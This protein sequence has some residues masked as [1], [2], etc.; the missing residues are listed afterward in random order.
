MEQVVTL[1]RY[2]WKNKDG[3][4]DV[5]YKDDE[6]R[7]LPKQLMD[8]AP[9]IPHRPPQT[10]TNQERFDNM[11]PKARPQQPQRNICLTP[12]SRGITRFDSNRCLR[13]LTPKVK[14]RSLNDDMEQ[15]R[16]SSSP[17]SPSSSPD[18]FQRFVPSRSTSDRTP[19]VA[20]RFENNRKDSFAKTWF[21]RCSINSVLHPPDVFGSNR[22]QEQDTRDGS[23]KRFSH[24][25]SR[26]DHTP[27]AVKLPS[28][29][30]EVLEHHGHGVRQLHMPDLSERSHGQ[31]RVTS[32][33]ELH[34][35]TTSRRFQR[36]SSLEHV[37]HMVRSAF[38][39]NAQLK[40]PEAATPRS[41]AYYDDNHRSHHNGNERDED[42]LM[43]MELHIDLSAAGGDDS[44]HSQ[45]DF[46]LSRRQNESTTMLK[47]RLIR[48]TGGKMKKRARVITPVARKPFFFSKI[49]IR[50]PHIVSSKKRQTRNEEADRRHSEAEEDLKSENESYVSQ[51]EVEQLELIRPIKEERFKT[52]SRGCDDGT[53]SSH[54]SALSDFIMDLV[55]E[56]QE[57][58]E[59]G[60]P[61]TVFIIPDELHSNA[62]HDLDLESVNDGSGFSN[63]ENDV[64]EELKYTDNGRGKI[65]MTMS[66]GSD[67]GTTC[68]N[69][70]ALRDFFMNTIL[71]EQEIQPQTVFIISNNFG[72]LELDPEDSPVV[73]GRG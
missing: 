43:S 62:M 7:Q 18:S 26:C 24:N 52:R 31:N 14:R 2:F 68:S 34:L 12:K 29:G 53:T 13:Y 25:R 66:D 69:S 5:D 22:E 71:L 3:D 64:E 40:S 37:T 57:G 45:D 48:N 1:Q 72:C 15:R 20:S 59:S 30:E 8:Q 60:Q 35:T 46:M 27:R 19:Q 17:Q 23:L 42:A 56:Q 55:E 51:S 41:R 10:P 65:I 33:E 63:D 6:N 36:R 32:E 9:G 49:P 70:P 21:R 4:S 67:D 58:D 73:I 11:A 54:S 47:P 28:R 16:E 50:L 61:Q 44:L 39:M 38:G